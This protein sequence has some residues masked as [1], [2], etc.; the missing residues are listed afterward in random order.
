MSS[1]AEGKVVL[2]FEIVAVRFNCTKDRFRKL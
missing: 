2:R 1:D